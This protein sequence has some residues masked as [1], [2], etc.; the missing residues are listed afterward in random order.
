M[1]PL[2]QSKST[3][4][5]YV[6]A[7]IPLGAMLGF[8]LSVSG[9]LKWMET[10]GLTVPITLLLALVCLSPWYSCRFL[11]L[12]RASPWKLLSNHLLAAICASAIVLALVPFLLMLLGKFH[13]GLER[14]I[15]P[16]LPV[17]AGMVFLFYLLS[18][19]LHYV[20][21]AVESSRQAEVLSREAELKALKAQV[22]PHFLFNSLNSISALTSVDPAKAREMCVRLSDFLRNSLRLGERVTIPFGE[23]LA[24]TSTYL[25]VEQVRFGQRL[26]IKQDF[27]PACT[28]CEVPPLLVQPLVENAIKHG[29]ATLTDGGEIAMSAHVHQDRLRFTVENPFDP[30]APAQKKS[31][32]GLVNVRNRLKARYGSAAKLDVQVEPGLYRVVLSMPCG[33]KSGARSTV[34]E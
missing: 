30:D 4:L 15:H 2:F 16:A 27:E 24:L 5:A 6:A 22:N 8:M 3:L 14:R 11:P 25:D 21:L 32:F 7:W 1:H 13:A 28:D 33:G 34:L 10:I 31:G 9:R 29:I 23:E 17:L 20:L 12:N 19:A 18:I 26:R